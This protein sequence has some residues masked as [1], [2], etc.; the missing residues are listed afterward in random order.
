M[1]SS[2]LVLREIS[3]DLADARIAQGLSAGAQL[4]AEE[5]AYLQ[6]TLTSMVEPRIRALL[7]HRGL[8][9]IPGIG[10]IER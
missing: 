2:D 10:K 9:E 5:Q 6:A 8:T 7:R 1:C 3:R 4:S